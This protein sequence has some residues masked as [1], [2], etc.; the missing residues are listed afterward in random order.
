MSEHDRL[1]SRHNAYQSI[2][3]E[4]LLLSTVQVKE[5]SLSSRLISLTEMSFPI[6]FSS[7]LGVSAR[8]T[9]MYFAKTISQRDGDTSLFAGIALALTFVNGIYIDESIVFN[10]KKLYVQFLSYQLQMDY[11]QL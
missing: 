8:C 4:N 6:I 1:P 7:L 9:I 3:Q 2:P 11:L 10:L 5:Q